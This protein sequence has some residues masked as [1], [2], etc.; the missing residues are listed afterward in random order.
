[1][2]FV[3]KVWRDVCGFRYRIPARLQQPSHHRQ[4]VAYAIGRLGADHVGP[5]GPAPVG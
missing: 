3:A 1:M 5:Y 4:N 2:I